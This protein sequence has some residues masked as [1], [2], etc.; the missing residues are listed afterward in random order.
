MGMVSGWEWSRGCG[1]IWLTARRRVECRDN[2]EGRKWLLMF[3]SLS[4]RAWGKTKAIKT[5]TQK[6]NRRPINPW[7]GFWVRGM[8]STPW[9]LRCDPGPCLLCLAARD[10]ARPV[11]VGSL[12]SKQLLTNT[13]PSLCTCLLDPRRN[14]RLQTGAE[15]SKKDD[16]RHKFHQ[17]SLITT[18]LPSFPS[19]P[20][21]E[22]TL[23]MPVLAA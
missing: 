22:E 18:Q 20:L 14:F 4:W 2:I 5:S 8:E 19:S 23:V 10:C 1:R 16:K 9:T 6:S 21:W 3:V 7:W 15:C 17:L 11:R 13:R 12:L